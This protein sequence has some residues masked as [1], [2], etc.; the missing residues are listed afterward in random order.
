MHIR[1]IRRQYRWLLVIVV[2]I[3]VLAA[4]CGDDDDSTTAGSATTVAPAK[5]PTVHVIAKD[6]SFEVPN[7]PSGVVKLEL[8]N[9]GKQP[10]DFQLARIDG[11][12]TNDEI[13]NIVSDQSGP[14]PAWLHGAGGVGTVGPGG[15]AGVAWVSLDPGA[16]Y[17]YFCTESDDNNKPHV[18]MGMI[19]DATLEGAS[20]VHVL[21]EADATVTAREYAFT[22]D[23]IT[24]GQQRVEFANDGPNQLHHFVAFPMKPGATLDQVKQAL[25]SQGPPQGEPP[26]D[27]ERAVVAAVVDPG[28]K[29]ILQANFA[30]GNWVF[31]CFMNDRAGGPPHLTKGMI[32][33]VTVSAP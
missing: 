11:D 3:A 21:P 27:F 7:I 28:H 4:G 22:I 32:S 8:E 10:H 17:V 33:E 12:H 30:P 26:V 31:V 5:A 23:G 2:A 14:I 1:T 15:P 13:A 25:L 24:A 19:G 16:H 20:P 18:K 29:E 6:F 9:Q